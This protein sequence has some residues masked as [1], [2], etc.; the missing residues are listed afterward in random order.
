MIH[1]VHYF[2]YLFLI[3][4]LI[5]CTLCKAHLRRLSSNGRQLKR[6]TALTD[7]YVSSSTTL[8]IKKN[9]RDR[10]EEKL[11]CQTPKNWFIPYRNDD[12]WTLEEK[13]VPCGHP[14]ERQHENFLPVQFF[15]LFAGN[16]RREVFENSL[17]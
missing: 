7:V 12:F 11:R 17:C 2:L 16:L 1:M 9:S 6:L 4:F 14:S 8:N 13:E 15:L 5:I 3:L 10:K